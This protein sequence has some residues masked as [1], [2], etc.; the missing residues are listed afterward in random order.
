MYSG[1]S[2]GAC[3]R[4]RQ[5]FSTTPCLSP[6]RNVSSSPR[7]LRTHACGFR[8]RPQPSPQRCSWRSPPSNPRQHPPRRAHRDSPARDVESAIRDLIASCRPR[9]RRSSRLFTGRGSASRTLLVC[10][11][12]PPRPSVDGI[13]EA[14]NSFSQPPPQPSHKEPRACTSSSPGRLPCSRLFRYHPN[15]AGRAPYQ[16]TSAV[17]K[18]EPRRPRGRRADITVYYRHVYMRSRKML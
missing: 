1:T 6:G 5:T 3:R 14:K 2:N 8:R 9:W 18:R 16:F 17:I 11:A 12:L 13:D 7:A 4:R 15:I 10:K